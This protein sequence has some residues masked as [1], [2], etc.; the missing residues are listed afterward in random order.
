MM[1][2]RS[3]GGAGEIAGI[4]ATTSTGARRPACSS[5]PASASTPIWPRRPAVGRRVEQLGGALSIIANWL[6]YILTCAGRRSPWTLRVLVAGRAASG[7]PEFADAGP[8]RPPPAGGICC[9]R[10][11]SSAASTS[12][13]FR[14]RRG[15]PP[16]DADADGSGSEVRAAAWWCLGAQRRVARR[17]PAVGGDPR[18]GEPGR[19]VQRSA[20]AQPGR[21]DGGAALGVCLQRRAAA[22]SGL[23]RNASAPAPCSAI[24]SRRGRSHRL[25]RGPRTG[26]RAAAARRAEDQHRSPEAAAGISVHQSGAGGGPGNHPGQSALPQSQLHIPVD[27][28][29]QA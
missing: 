27:Q 5:A 22:G 9:C 14:P 6:S 16:F 8:R 15:L 1:P 20:G 25:G 24:R 29:R 11:R 28:L 26:R 12:P 4:P 23:Y 10:R 7:L 3:R 2:P 17:Q 13:V 19:L 18:I 21:A